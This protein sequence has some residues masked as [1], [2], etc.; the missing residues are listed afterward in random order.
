MDLWLPSHDYRVRSL[1]KITFAFAPTPFG[2]CM[3]LATNTHLLA[4][5]FTEERE[6]SLQEFQLKWQSVRPSLKLRHGR[7][8][9]AFLESLFQKREEVPVLA[10]GTPFQLTVW[11]FLR[12]IPL[13][14][15]MTYAD[16]AKAIGHEGASR[17]V[18]Q[19]VGA[20]DLA[21]AIP[22][23]RVVSR[24]SLTGYRWGL[25]RKRKL[26]AWELGEL[27]I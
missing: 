23:H 11:E 2:E 25:E 3:A 15:T 14:T 5:H 13:G 7:H 21:V 20:N 26:L 4:L 22:C 1:K 9:E 8:A 24:N 6:K 10:V 18:G 27:I 19:A 17:A 12:T 16:V